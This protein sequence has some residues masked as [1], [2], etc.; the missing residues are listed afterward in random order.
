MRYTL[1]RQGK[2]FSLLLVPHQIGNS[3]KHTV[4]RL[5][6]WLSF[7]LEEL[8]ERTKLRP[9]YCTLWDDS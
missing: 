3:Y 8:E 2:G 7:S 6:R 9:E 5:N 4:Y 1:D